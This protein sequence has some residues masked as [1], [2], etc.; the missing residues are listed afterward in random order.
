MDISAKNVPRASKIAKPGGKAG[1]TEA[2]GRS[3]SAWWDL[4]W[5]IQHI[6]RRKFDDQRRKRQYFV[7]TSRARKLV[8]KDG[9][10]HR[11]KVAKPLPG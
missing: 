3:Q 10:H 1:M 2:S 11:R 5:I 9:T 7:T 4:A 6:W 8:T